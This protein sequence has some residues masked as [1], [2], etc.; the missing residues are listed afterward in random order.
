MTR[1]EEL[2]EKCK[3]FYGDETDIKKRYER[4]ESAFFAAHNANYCD[5][6][7][8]ESASGENPRVAYWKEACQLRD[9]VEALLG[10]YEKE[11]T[12]WGSLRRI[13]KKLFN[14]KEKR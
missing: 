10:I 1:R 12:V 13:C 4:L 14:G 2:E 5:S 9:E 11:L 8:W 7:A 6:A 3:T